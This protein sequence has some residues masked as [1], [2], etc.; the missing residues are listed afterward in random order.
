MIAARPVKVLVQVAVQKRVQVCVLIRVQV[1]VR[2]LRKMKVLIAARPVKVRVQAG[3]QLRVQVGVQIIVQVVVRILRKEL[4][5]RPIAGITAKHPVWVVAMVN[6]KVIAEVPVK[7]DARET[8][9]KTANIL[10]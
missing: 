5:N 1:V 6:A 8:V 3:V 4:K 7:M 10:A 9:G 2:V